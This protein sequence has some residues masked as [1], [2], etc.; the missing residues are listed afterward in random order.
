MS[1][2]LPQQVGGRR[3]RAK[4]RHQLLDLILG[5]AGSAIQI[6]GEIPQMLLQR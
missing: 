4:V 5:S 2:Q 1:W 3:L 6:P